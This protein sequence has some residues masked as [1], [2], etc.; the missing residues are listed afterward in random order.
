MNVTIVHRDRL[1]MI[2]ALQMDDAN[3]KK[4]DDTFN[5]FLGTFRVR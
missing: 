3:P 5:A 2:T 4:L 1:Y